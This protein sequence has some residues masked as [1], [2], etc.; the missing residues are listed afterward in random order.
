MQTT[1]QAIKSN[2][3]SLPL[4]HAYSSEDLLNHLNVSPQKG[5]SE[6]EIWSQRA[7]YG[8][9]RLKAYRPKPWWK[10]LWEQF[11]NP[12]IYLLIGATLLSF[13]FSEWLEGTAIIVVILLTVLIGFFMEWQAIRSMEALRQMAQT[14]CRVMRKGKEQ[15]IGAE[16]LVPGDML[17][18]EMGE[19]VPAD[20]RV[21]QHE[22]LAVK[23][24]ALTGE[25]TQ[26]DKHNQ[27]LSEQTPMIDRTNMVFN[28]TLVSRGFGK[29]LV[30][31]TGED[32]ELG[33]ISRLTKAASASVTPLE[34]KLNSLSRKLIWVTFG[35]ML[36]IL[37]AGLVQGKDLIL[38]VKTAIALA[39][40]AIPEGLPIVATIALA[41]GM[42]RLSKQKVIIKNLQAVQ[43]LG[44]V[45]TICTDKTGTLTENSMEV[46]EFYP[47]LPELGPI[48]ANP[49]PAVSQENIE[50]LIRISILCNDARQNENNQWVGDALDVSLLEWVETLGYR[51]QEFRKDHPEILEIPFDTES[52]MMAT[53][54]QSEKGWIVSVKGA[55][56][57]VLE[58]CSGEWQQ[59]GIKPITQQGKLWL[60]ETERMAARGL[61]TLA[62]AYR[63]VETPPQPEE[64][65]QDLIMLGLMG[66]R[67]PPRKDIRHAMET[68]HKAGIKV[69]MVTGD[70]PETARNIAQE[71]GL[72]PEEEKKNTVLNGGQLEAGLH[73]D[74]ERKQQI[75]DAYVFARVNP[76]QKLALVET[77]Q[78]DGRII[79]MTGDGVNDAPALKKA[80]IGIAMGVRGTEAAKEVA[81]IILQDDRF[82]SIEMAI[83]QGRIIF[84]N[85]RKFVVYLLSCNLAEILA[86]TIASLSALPL[87][88]LPLQIL[89]LNLVTDVFPSLALGMGEG[90]KH[91]MDQPPRPYNAPILS[92]K[93]WLSTVLYGLGIALGVIGITLFGTHY[94]QLPD[95]QVN[96]LAFYTLVVSQLIHVF[97]MT[98]RKASFIRN[99]ITRNPWVWAAILL[100][101]V[102]TGVGYLIPAFRDALHLIPIDWRLLKWVFAFAFGSVILIQLMKRTKLTV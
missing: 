21:I 7:K 42:L 64:T 38:M 100:C 70:H 79:G 92:R 88:L 44:E 9:N 80:D 81:D 57:N 74:S 99:E 67:D 102:L 78:Q 12:I 1:K 94:L 23:E 82:S 41:R 45:S 24:S 101:L 26:V 59:D 46:K 76:A 17:L 19:V 54:N 5:L 15:T 69:V 93:L 36:L 50:N 18:L 37:G 75:L 43:T 29:V 33:Q 51:I 83:R 22:N 32:T 61:R 11:F 89:Y 40:A 84:E 66:F 25:S 34:K 65:I 6:K 77:L 72:L 90:G 97:N 30:T 91:I 56:E 14:H 49:N 60:E 48:G 8:P 62:F 63:K 31:A 3:F 47:N 53:V 85:I 4:A 55:V 71:V 98:D 58:H 52:K 16:E 87:P 2:S 27:P 86:V 73:A 28:G 68:C 10:I 20:G 96:N 35:L 13:V 95:G 39:V